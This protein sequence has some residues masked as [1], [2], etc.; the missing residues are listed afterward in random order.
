MS[1]MNL[2]FKIKPPIFKVAHDEHEAHFRPLYASEAWAI[3]LFLRRCGIAEKARLVR[4]GKPV[5][6][7]LQGLPDTCEGEPPKPIGSVLVP[8][9]A[10]VITTDEE[11]NAV[12][13]DKS[14]DHCL[15]LGGNVVMNWQKSQ[16]AL[17]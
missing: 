9:V 8:N 5:P 2:D 16:F 15:E 4:E 7:W 10:W 14:C 13:F 17:P 3:V 11:G 1:T 12:E 6:I